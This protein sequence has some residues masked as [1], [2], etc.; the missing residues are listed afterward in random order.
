MDKEWF[1]NATYLVLLNK[2]RFAPMGDPMFS[3]PEQYKMFQEEIKKKYPGPVEH[4]A[5][6]K[7]IGW[8]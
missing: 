2:Q 4:T 8:N 3:D 6:S 5:A 1:E 7:Q